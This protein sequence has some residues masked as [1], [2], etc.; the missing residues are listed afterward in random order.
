MRLMLG[1]T[2]LT[3]TVW[4]SVLLL[5]LSLSLTWTETML[6]AGPSGNEQTKLPPLA[7]VAVVPTSLPFAPQLV[8]TTLNVSWPGSVTVNEYVWL[9]PSLT[10]R[11][12][13]AARLTVGAT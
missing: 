2:L 13:P 1:A 3:V 11:S 5:A 9:V 12:L 6:E 4:V 8:L 10:L 7:V